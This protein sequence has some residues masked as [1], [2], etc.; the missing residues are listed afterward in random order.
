MPSA[1]NLPAEY[2]VGVFETK[3]EPIKFKQVKLELPN[4]GEVCMMSC[5]LS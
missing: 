3:G 4:S 1:P 2:K 5:R